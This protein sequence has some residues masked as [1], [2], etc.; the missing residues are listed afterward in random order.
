VDDAVL[1]RIVGFILLALLPVIFIHKDMGV[2]RE[3]VTAVRKF[4]G[5]CLDFLISVWGGFFAAGGGILNRYVWMHFFG[6]TI[7]EVSA[8]N[9]IPWLVS[10]VVVLLTFIFAGV[11]H[12]AYGL[13]LF[14][15]MLVGGY[16]GAHWA[17]KRGDRWVKRAFVVFVVISAVQL[18]FFA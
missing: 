11:V 1:S 14:L 5:Y 4:I 8:T 10:S 13:T 17:V 2:R 6:L 3:R 18:I 16:L 15:G 7:I 12:Y 9:K